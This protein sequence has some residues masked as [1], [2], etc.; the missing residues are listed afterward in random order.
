MK[1][2]LN[3]VKGI[4]QQ[5]VICGVDKFEVSTLRGMIEKLNG[6][7]HKGTQLELSSWSNSTDYIVSKV[8]DDKI[9]VKMKGW[10]QYE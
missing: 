7:I 9:I 2:L 10:E 6:N 4:K 5:V 8:T 3:N 1:A